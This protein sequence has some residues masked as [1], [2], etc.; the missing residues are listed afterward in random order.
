VKLTTEQRDQ[1]DA[2]I[3]RELEIGPVTAYVISCRVERQLKDRFALDWRDIDRA[4]QRLRKSGFIYP[5]RDRSFSYWQIV[6][7]LP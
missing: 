5:R 4:L 3:I 7:E 6:K 1:I 2:A